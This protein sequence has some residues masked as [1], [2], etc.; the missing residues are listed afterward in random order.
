MQPSE[1]LEV[2]VQLRRGKEAARKLMRELLRKQGF[3]PAEITTDGLRSYGAG[4]TE[5]GP[6]A[7]HEQGPRKNS[8]AEVSHRL[9]RQQERKMQRF[10]S[11]G[12]AQ[13]FL[14][15]HS[16]VCNTINLQCHLISRRALR[17]VRAEAIARW[18]AAASAA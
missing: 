15:V 1:V 18:H 11:P 14:S 10:K 2:L 6:T 8:R 16:A 7:R 3:A 4:F 13:R 12:S 17:A 5:I 9:V